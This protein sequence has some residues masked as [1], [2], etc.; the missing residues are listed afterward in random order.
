MKPDDVIAHRLLR[1]P[2]AQEGAF[3]LFWINQ[4][5]EKALPV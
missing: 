2:S 1:F 3:L 4:P 5:S